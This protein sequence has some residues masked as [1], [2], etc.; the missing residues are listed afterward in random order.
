[1]EGSIQIDNSWY[2]PA[3]SSRA[4]DRT[5]VL[6]SGESFGVFSR[7]GEI[8]WVGF[9]EQGFYFFGTRHLSFWHIKLAEREPMLLNSMV[10]L[11][12][13][14]LVVDQTTPDMFRDEELWLP[15]GSLLHR[16]NA[17]NIPCKAASRER[18]ARKRIA[19]EPPGSGR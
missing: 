4:D 13:S 16:C 11:D 2:I 14:R 17:P 10:R 1:M 8:S 5:R 15:K 7:H 6:K 3:T 18:R 12:N 19:P 9:G